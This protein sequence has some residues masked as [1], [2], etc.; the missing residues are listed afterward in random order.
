MGRL[1]FYH[2]QLA[3]D[4]ESMQVQIA[5]PEKPEPCWPLVLAVLGPTALWACLFL[6]FPP[7]QQNFPLNDDC[8]YSRTAFAFARGKGLDYYNQ[9]SLPL[10]GL[11]L[12]AT[13]FMWLAGDSII[14]L[15]VATLILGALGIVGLYDLLR[16]S[17]GASS[18]Q[19]AV[20]AACLGLNPLYFLMSCVFQSDVPTLT[21]SL[22][23]LSCYQRGLNRRRLRWWLAGM[24]LALLAVS[25]RQ[26]A[27]SVPVA[28][29]A[30][31]LAHGGLRRRPE[32]LAGIVLPLAT[33]VAL[34]L[35]LSTR[36]DATHLGP[37]WTSLLIAPIT[38]FVCVHY[39][40]LFVVPLLLLPGPYS[41]RAFV[42]SVLVL[43][44]MATFVALLKIPSEAQRAFQFRGIFPYWGNMI[45]P[46][47]QMEE[48][49]TNPGI[50]PE[51]MDLTTR[52]VLTLAGCLAG[53]GLLARLAARFH[54][55]LWRE[56]LPL[57]TLV[58]LALLFISPIR[59]D[60][61][62]LMLLPGGLALALGL[63]ETWKVRLSLVL[64]CLMGLLSFAWVHD[65]LSWNRALWDLGRRA[66]ARGIDPTDI[67]GGFTWNGWHSPHGADDEA[68]W[69][70]RGK[71][72]PFTRGTFP[73]VTGRY[74]LSFSTDMKSSFLDSEPYTLW[75][76]PG[77]HELT[78][79]GPEPPLLVP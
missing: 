72:L 17:I 47:G 7:S 16:Q 25:T 8:L 63:M 43:L 60:R 65:Y 76:A 52:L 23:A 42:T 3:T 28:A 35:W 36:P 64:L 5:D 56:L 45:T 78:L 10:I 67:E 53:A 70:E 6:L 44:G 61:Y 77:H 24:V 48:N 14:V 19:A 49:F 55:G 38:V 29:G 59:Y 71:T 50:R 75:L 15:R 32:W 21:F 12:W 30:M 68:R 26:N 4:N 74:S 37:N 31:L 13:P 73:H 40:G 51:V 58:H 79:L 18:R 39:L 46:V 66:L 41:R 2:R 69:E 27:L 54:R 9:S 22:F 62:L 34:D 20:A 33:V 1:F 57:F 11:L